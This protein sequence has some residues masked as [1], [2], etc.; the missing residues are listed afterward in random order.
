MSLPIFIGCPL[1][2]SSS[3]T[4]GWT[5]AWLVHALRS[6]CRHID[7]QFEGCG[8]RGQRVYPGWGRGDLERLILNIRMLSMYPAHVLLI[9]SLA[10]VRVWSRG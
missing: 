9:S 1:N 8:T 5:G 6:I 4:V 2:Y 7:E 10:F 3:T